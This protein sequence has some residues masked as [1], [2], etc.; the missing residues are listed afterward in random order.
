MMLPVVVDV[1]WGS[2]VPWL[3]EIYFTDVAVDVGRDEISEV[4]KSK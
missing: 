4:N 3:I 1:V 2:S